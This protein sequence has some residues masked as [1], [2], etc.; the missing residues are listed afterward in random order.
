MW[1]HGMCCSSGGHVSR[2]AQMNNPLE[3]F[4]CHTDSVNFAARDQNL[5]YYFQRLAL[6]KKY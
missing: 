2:S 1:K 6:P 5:P 3:D 4:G